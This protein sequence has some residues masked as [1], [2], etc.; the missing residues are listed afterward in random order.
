MEN[1]VVKH[2]VLYCCTH[3]VSPKEFITGVQP[4]FTPFS[5]FSEPFSA[6]LCHFSGFSSLTLTKIQGQSE[7]YYR[8]T[9]SPFSLVFLLYSFFSIIRPND[10][11]PGDMFPIFLGHG[12]KNKSFF[13][14][15][16]VSGFMVIS[17]I[18]R[19]FRAGQTPCSFKNTFFILKFKPKHK[20][21][22]ASNHS[23]GFIISSRP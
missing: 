8:M 14:V 9:H 17:S 15:F 7:L 11:I 10:F 18:F 13:R 4:L 23:F 16:R 22:G 1:F 6:E 2:C 20:Y 3:H 21:E 19:V 12:S 5:G